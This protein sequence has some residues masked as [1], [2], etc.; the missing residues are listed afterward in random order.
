ME[1]IGLPRFFSSHNSVVRSVSFNPCDRYLFCSGGN[2]GNICMFHAGRAELLNIYSVISVGINR[3]VSAVR[4][5]SDGKKVN[6][7]F[8]NQ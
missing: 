6:M 3:Y 8:S 5:N 7:D 2:D 4:F 1:K